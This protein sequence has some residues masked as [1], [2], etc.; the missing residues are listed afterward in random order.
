MISVMINGVLCLTIEDDRIL[1]N[2][3]IVDIEN[4]E[5]KTA[6]WSQSFMIENTAEVNKLFGSIFEVNLDIQNTSE[7][8]F[9]TDFNPNLKASIVILNDNAVVFRGYCQMEDI[10][11]LDDNK[12]HYSIIAIAGQGNFFNDI[13]NKT[14]DDLDFSD[15]NHTW[16]RAN[17]EASWT[18]TLGTGYVYPMIDYGLTTD[19]NKWTSTAFRP[20]VFVKDIIDRMFV[21]AGWS[22]SSSFFTSTRFKSLIIPFSAENLF[23]DNDEIYDRSF[24]ISNSGSITYT[25]AAFMGSL[26]SASPIIFNT[27][28]G[29]DLHNTIGSDYDTATGKWTCATSGNYSFGIEITLNQINNS[30]SYAATG[31]VNITLMKDSG[32]TITFHDSI[33]ATFTYPAASSTSGYVNISYTSLPLNIDSGD[34]IY[35][36]VNQGRLRISGAY[37][38]SSGS[39][40]DVG[41]SANGYFSLIPQSNLFYGDTIDMNAL[42][43]NDIK[44][45]DFIISLSKM[46]NLYFDQTDEKT[47]LIE[48]RE[49]YFTSDTVDWT[50]KLDI[51]QDVKFTPMG[52]SQ[53]KRYKFTYT[54]DGDLKN[55]EYLKAYQQVYG[56]ALIDI[57]TDFLTETK[58]IKTSFA[59]TPLSNALAGTNNRIIS[60]MRFYDGTNVKSGQTKLRILYWGGML[61]CSTW[62]LYTNAIVSGGASSKTSYPYA[63]HLDNPY[64]PTFDLCYSQPEA[65]FYNNNIGGGGDV[66]YTDSNLYTQYWYKNIREITNKNSKVL[67]AMFNLS[68]FDFLTLSFRKQYFIKDAY[69]RLLEVIDYDIQGD[70]LV[71]CRL[72]KVDREQ[73][74]TTSSKL[75]RGGTAIFDAGGKVP[76]RLFPISKDGIKE[77][78]DKL[79]DGADGY[80]S[81]KNTVNMGSTNVITNAGEKVYIFGSDNVNVINEKVFVFNTDNVDIVREGAIFNGV[82]LERKFEITVDDTYLKAIDGGV[83]TQILPQL[84][85]NEHYLITRFYTEVINN[86]TSYAWTGTGDITLKTDTDNTLLATV[87]GGQWLG[88]LSGIGFGTVTSAYNL[89][90][91]INIAIAGTWSSGSPNVRFIIWYKI[92]TV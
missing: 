79:F 46:F 62:L 86:G 64:T 9:T 22:Y 70:S 53:Q 43:P 5:Q 27:D 7:V 71:K 3:R 20:A 50:G 26:L 85:T 56:T 49:D 83:G 44:Q 76:T 2:K 31:T 16:T 73:G 30:G 91:H 38:Y 58:E 36:V 78:K 12:I 80:N 33:V 6:D 59:A 82:D 34:D 32:G 17:I 10:I 72:L 28:S 11:I 48:P 66:S 52:M 18:P 65:V 47:L 39:N 40:I 24:L 69:Y 87:A 21:S 54:E 35:W 41:I 55:D 29:G 84:G 51:G 1:I 42:L 60:D 13:K 88:L 68:I 67:E 90:R 57:V 15:L 63:G 19:Y 37:V 14:L 8:N 81:G 89:L 92:I 25:L 45:K 77:R 61:P 23:I 74:Y 75:L 4:P